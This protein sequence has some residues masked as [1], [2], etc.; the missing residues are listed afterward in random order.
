MSRVVR[1]TDSS[2]TVGTPVLPFLRPLRFP[3]PFTYTLL[4][5]ASAGSGDWRMQLTPLQRSTLSNIS[6]T[7]SSS[8]SASCLRRLS[9][10]GSRSSSPWRFFRPLWTAHSSSSFTESQGTN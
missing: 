10:S 6:R 4:I 9:S 8:D 1:S 5:S 7:V 3:D 2:S